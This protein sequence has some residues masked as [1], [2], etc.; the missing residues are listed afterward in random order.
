M[1]SLFPFAYASHAVSAL[2]ALAHLTACGERV[3][4]DPYNGTAWP[5]ERPTVPDGP[6]GLVTDSLSDTL[7]VVDLASGEV[8]LT[9]PIGR[10]PVSIDG[11]HHVAVDLDAGVAYVPLSYPATATG[12]HGG[13]G[14]SVRL[15]WVQMVSLDDLRILGQVRV[16]TSPGDLAL[17]PDGSRL[18]VSHFDLVRAAQN[19]GDVEAA[20][21]VLAIIKKGNVL[22]SGSPTPTLVSTCIAAHGVIFVSDTT[23]VLACYGEDSLVAVDVAAAKVTARVPVGPSATAYSPSYGPYALA[24]S[25]DGAWLAVSHTES[26][27]VRLFDTATLTLDG[28]RILPTFGSPLFPWFSAD[29]SKLYVPTQTPDG[30][31]VFDVESGTEVARRDF[32]PGE[33]VL[34]HEVEEHDG[35]LVVVCEGDHEAPGTLLQLDATDLSTLRSTPVGVFPDA[36]ERLPAG[37]RSGQ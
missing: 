23:A 19:P 20:R 35:E 32:A 22:P 26:D 17:S 12:P 9:A 15:G 21:S 30:L 34:P 27:D 33:C 3:E 13:H 31:S 28:D 25:P 6:V 5:S 37:W 4:Y 2:L 14:T 10:D 16:D 8:A 18:V 36:V 11:P 1:K 24:R 7:S 29:G